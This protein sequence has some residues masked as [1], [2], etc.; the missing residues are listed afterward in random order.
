[1]I[2]FH[3]RGADPTDLAGLAMDVPEH[4]RW[5]LPR[6]PVAIEAGTGIGFGWFATDPRWATLATDV[7]RTAAVARAR[8][9]VGA[10]VDQLLGRLTVPR[11]RTLLMGFSQGAAIALHV[12]LASPQ[13]FAGIVSMS[14]YFPMPETLTG[15]GLPRPQPI[16]IVHGIFDQVL[17]VKLGREAKAALEAA[18]LAPRYR[19]FSM[20][21]RIT[22]KSYGA[23]RDFLTEVLP[24][25]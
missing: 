24:P 2:C 22:P 11:D 6:G 4:Y 20:D 12:G 1:M 13:P 10:F 3:G 18:G 21:H 7:E 8:Q 17:N 15:T 16:L 19:E 9:E 5:V 14:G 23:V 25:R